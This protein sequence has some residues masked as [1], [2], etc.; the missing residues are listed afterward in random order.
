M[1]Q[2]LSKVSGALAALFAGAAL[3]GPSAANAPESRAEFVRRSVD[4]MCTSPKPVLVIDVFTRR[5]TPGSPYPQSR[6]THDFDG[7]GMPDGAHGDYVS[8]IYEASGKT[9]VPFNM[10]ARLRSADDIVGM[11]RSLADRLESGAIEK[12]AAI[13]ISAG[14]ILF[15]R[16]LM[17]HTPAA[18]AAITAT[19]KGERG[20][21]ALAFILQDTSEYTQYY[22]DIYEVFGRLAAIGVPIIVAAG[23]DNCAYA[24]AVNFLSLMPGV[25]TVGALD[26]KGRVASYS[27]ESSLVDLHST[28]EF[29]AR[30][31]EGGIDING[32]NIPEFPAAQLSAGETIASRYAGKNL[33]EVLVK[34]PP[35]YDTPYTIGRMLQTDALP[36]GIYPSAKIIEREHLDTVGPYTHYPSHIDFTITPD[37]RLK[38]DPAG[39]GDPAKVMRFPPGTSFAAPNICAKPAL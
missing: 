3:C 24:D 39:D 2:G 19:E 18:R 20:R 5:A 6:R 21:Q 7:D 16:E 26:H 32:D 36:E 25:I 14:S 23:N 17:E 29:F 31:V 15:F 13:N 1:I 28:G 11:Y 38:F 4:E 10:P 9:V 12:P 35:A 33:D 8:A 34:I 30:E 27:C 37:R 22:R